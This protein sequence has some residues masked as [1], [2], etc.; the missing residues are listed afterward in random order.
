MLIHIGYHK[1]GT[2]FF[3]SGLFAGDANGFSMPWEQPRIREQIVLSSDFDWSPTEVRRGFM[4]DAQPLIERNLVPVISDERLSGSPHAGGYDSARTA[5]R[6]A[7]LFPEAQVLI[8]IR[9]QASAIDSMYQQYVRNGGSAPVQKY[10]RPRHHAE[11]PQF[12][13]EH[14]EY[15]HLIG[16]YQELFTAERVLVLPYEELRRDVDS[17]I[18]RVCRLVGEPPASGL[19]GRRYASLSA[20]GTELKRQANR[21]YFRG[22]LNPSAPFYVRDLES[23]FERIDR[24]LPSRFS[25]GIAE[26]RRAVVEMDSAGRFAE[27]NRKTSTLARIDLAGLGYQ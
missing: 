15:H 18:A 19:Q 7:E 26:R 24:W 6:L 22:A 9:E 25:R 2:T 23:R 14:W 21:L 1:T 13:Y 17:A 20:A 12:R 4:L 27:S 11:I 3:Q 16:L 5:Y 8:G 10:L